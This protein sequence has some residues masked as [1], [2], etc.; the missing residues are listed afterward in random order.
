M[1][2]CMFVS[3]QNQEQVDRHLPD[4]SDRRRPTRSSSNH[5]FNT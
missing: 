1:V 2:D 3:C 5:L 4:P